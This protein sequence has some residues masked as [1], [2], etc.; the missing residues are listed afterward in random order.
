MTGIDAM[1]E[2]LALIRKPGLR[3]FVAVPLAINTS[4]FSVLIWFSAG[5]FG[6]LMTRLT[7]WLPD[8]LDWLQWLLWP[9]FAITV[10]VVLFY[11]FTACANLLA[12][13][14][15]G[16]LAEAVER[17]LTGQS[18]SQPGDLKALI[19]DLIPAMLNE[20]H[21]IFYALIW[22][23]P[24]AVLFVIPGVNIVAPFAW[25]L[26]S[27]WMLALT[28]MDY[29]MDNHGIRFR[30]QRRRYRRQRGLVQGFGLAALGLTMIPVVNFLAMPAAV[31]GAT[32]LY[33][34]RFGE[35]QV[36]QA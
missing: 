7:A 33:V 4:L 26:F 15:N 10:G 6:G 19:R 12:A 14:F 5:W 3:R 34:R 9:L 29:P 16:L 13:P 28:Y 8:W 11:G 31:A 2:G 30:A 1:R 25:A 20:L 36:E 27:A 22:A 23:I 32:A 24:F 17:H 35:G 21:K 18:P